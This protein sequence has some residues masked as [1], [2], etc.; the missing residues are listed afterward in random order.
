MGL[1]LDK[2]RPVTN[3]SYQKRSVSTTLPRR[4]T[5]VGAGVAG[6]QAVR[7]LKAQGFNV[8]ERF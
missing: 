5:V 4:V 7:A 8:C 3:C 1:S 2:H 6:L